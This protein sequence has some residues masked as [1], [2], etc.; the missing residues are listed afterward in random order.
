M[1]R[2]RAFGLVWPAAL[3]A[4]LGYL[5]GSL[6]PAFLALAGGS[7]STPLSRVGFV[8]REHTQAPPAA[9][10]ALGADLQAVRSAFVSPDREVFDLLVAVHGLDASGT[11]DWSR[12]ERICRALSWSRCEPS[13]LALLK[14]PSRP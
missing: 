9:W 11:S 10:A 14:E 12:A 3:S 7:S 4:A 6:L 1:T 5:L 13:T 8:L 2:A